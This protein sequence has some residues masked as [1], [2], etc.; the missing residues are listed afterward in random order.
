MVN[1]LDILINETLKM[2]KTKTKEQ[3][4]E[5]LKKENM[6]E[7]DINFVINGKMNKNKL[8]RQKRKAKLART[9]FC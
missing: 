3:Q 1:D 2:F 4:I 9:K 7:E 5:A 6:S 8:K